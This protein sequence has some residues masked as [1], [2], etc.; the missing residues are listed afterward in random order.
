VLRAN[1]RGSSGYGRP[2]RF[3]NYGDWGGG[4]YGDII[5]GVD[6]LIAQ[7]VADPDRLLIMG[8]SYGGYMT[9]W[10]ITQT[11]RFRAS[12]IRAGVTDLV[13]FTGTA[14]IPGFLPDYLGAEFWVEPKLYLQRSAL[15]N[16]QGVT[17]PA[18]IQHGAVDARVPLSQSLEFYNALKRQGVP[19]EMIIYPR[20]AHDMSEPRMAID[21]RKRP[22]EWF[23]KWVE[24]E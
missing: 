4:D 14:D 1:P 17:T 15:F 12:C 18:L 8:W 20:Q 11:H 7:G 22:V 16:A 5:A 9:S 19:V 2:F 24:S 21:V 13:S 6:A 3:A 23:A 10:A